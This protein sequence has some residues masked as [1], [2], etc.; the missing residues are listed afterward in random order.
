MISP[1][2]QKK[3]SLDPSPF[4]LLFFIFLLSFVHRWTAR[5]VA[6]WPKAEE[7]VFG[8]MGLAIMAG[9]VWGDGLAITGQRLQPVQTAALRHVVAATISSEVWRRQ[10]RLVLFS[11]SFAAHSVIMSHRFNSAN[12]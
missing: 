4:G 5:A 8:V 6:Q 12:K 2:N 1:V 10:L 7:D 11:V 3:T 9:C